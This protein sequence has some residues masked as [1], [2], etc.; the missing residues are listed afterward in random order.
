M[1]TCLPTYLPGVSEEQVL[2][3]WNTSHVRLEPPG[4]LKKTVRILE[5]SLMRPDRPGCAEGVCDVVRDMV[6]PPG[7]YFISGP[8]GTVALRLYQALCLFSS[9]E[10]LCTPPNHRASK[11]HLESFL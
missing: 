8:L 7:Y 6:R 4:P 1:H 5:K 11:T 3:T 10:A 2:E 9:Q